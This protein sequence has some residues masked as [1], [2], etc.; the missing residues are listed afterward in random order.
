MST[1]VV[2]NL[3]EQL[4]E[5]LK[6]QAQQHHRS[7]NKEAIAL[8]EQGLLAPRESAARANASPLPPLVRLPGGPLTAE[9]IEAAIADG[10]R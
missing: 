5:R 1:L 2:K 10:R 8:I 9:W 7:I 6:A 3:P 4:H